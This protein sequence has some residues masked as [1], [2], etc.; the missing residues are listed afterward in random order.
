MRLLGI[1]HLARDRLS[2]PEASTRPSS[3]RP[4]GRSGP[5]DWNCGRD[6]HKFHTHEVVYECRRAVERRFYAC[7]KDDH[8]VVQAFNVVL[9]LLPARGSR[10]GMRAACLVGL[11]SIGGRARIR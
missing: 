11:K 3:L 5:V 6:A 7:L 9:W 10:A 8:G 4:G 1:A 2:R